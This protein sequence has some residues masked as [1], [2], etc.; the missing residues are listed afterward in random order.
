MPSTIKDC[1]GTKSS[2]LV[3]AAPVV[4]SRTACTSDSNSRP[5]TASLKSAHLR[6]PINA[7]SSVASMPSGDEWDT[8]TVP[9]MAAASTPEA[10]SMVNAAASCAA[11]APAL[12]WTPKYGRTRRARAARGGT[13]DDMDPGNG[14]TLMRTA[15]ERESVRINATYVGGLAPMA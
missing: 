14:R 2:R 13:A 8:E 9:A 15:S 3:T 4:R 10:L 12:R 1:P 7:T 11:S 6:K 5:A